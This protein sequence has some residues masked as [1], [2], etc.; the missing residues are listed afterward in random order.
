M[1]ELQSLKREASSI[2]DL[3][4]PPPRKPRDADPVSLKTS[5]RDTSAALIVCG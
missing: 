3:A 5:T 2:E 4:K 1:A